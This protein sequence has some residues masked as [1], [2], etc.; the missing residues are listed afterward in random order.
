M[1]AKR[2]KK[3]DPAAPLAENAARIV[4]VRLAELHS[5]APR[6]LEPEAETE[7]H[8]MR[9]AAK[10]LRYVLEVAGFCLGSAAAKARRRARDLQDLLG[11]IHDCDVMLPR[12]EGELHEL[13]SRDARALRARA[14]DAPDLDAG[15]VAR[16]PGRTTYRGLEVFAAYLEARRSLLFDRFTSFWREQE[17][18]GTWDALERSAERVLARARERRRAE[19][20]VERAAERAR[21]LA[22]TDSAPDFVH[23]SGLLEEAF[24]LARHSHHDRRRVEDTDIEHPLSAA[25]LLEEAGYPPTVVAAALLHDV[26]EDTHTGPTEIEERVGSPVRE[27]VEAMTEDA[28]IVEYDVRKAEHRERVVAAGP[29]AAAIYAADKLATMR[30]VGSPANLPARRLT[31]FRSTYALLRDRYPTLPFLAELRERLEGGDREGAPS[32]PA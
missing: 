15:L 27:L 2:V 4:R 5:F 3:L 7:Q 26:V 9:I 24:E 25:A 30:A 1:K 14:G 12:V 23:R 20:A 17:R 11:E 29:E 19:R 13:R 16:A 31:H 21:E 6:A 18:K 8:D 10:R 32:G 28:S 22:Q